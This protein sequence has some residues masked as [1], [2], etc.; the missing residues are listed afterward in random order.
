MVYN[1]LFTTGIKRCCT[2]TFKEISRFLV[3]GGL[4]TALS[5]VT[6]LLLLLVFPYIVAYSIAY[7]LSIFT[8]YVLHSKIVFNEQLDKKKASMYP[9]L[10]LGLYFLNTGLLYLLVQ[11]LGVDEILAPIVVL[12]VVV[13]ATYVFGRLV[14]KGHLR[15][16]DP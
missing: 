12:I 6:Y 7:V 10:Y 14:I 5:Y 15:A 9:V 4:N 16:N 1:D 8:A 11:H 2:L 13:P 3:T